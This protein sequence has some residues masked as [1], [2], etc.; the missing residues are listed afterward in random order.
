[1]RLAVFR[2]RRRRASL[3]LA[4]LLAL[5]ALPLAACGKKADPVP[6]P[7]EPLEYPRP[8]PRQ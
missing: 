3:V 4:L 5:L 8:Y 6:P 1:M 7:G 2:S